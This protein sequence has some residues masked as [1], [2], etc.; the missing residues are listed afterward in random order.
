MYLEHCVQTDGLLQPHS[1]IAFGASHR[2][3]V[4]TT[5]PPDAPGEPL[6]APS[7]DPT[8]TPLAVIDALRAL[9]QEE[10][11]DHLGHDFLGLSGLS[12]NLLGERIRRA[13]ASMAGQVYQRVLATL[14]TTPKADA[15]WSP[16]N[17]AGNR[18][19][20][21]QTRP[22]LHGLPKVRKGHCH[23]FSCCCHK[24]VAHP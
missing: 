2:G 10:F 4:G 21:N 6:P 20:E 7:V 22:L 18:T 19:P 14:S 8:F 24:F 12:K 5:I 13:Y 3:S 9:H 23:T 16:S 15:K 17:Q 1:G 11:V